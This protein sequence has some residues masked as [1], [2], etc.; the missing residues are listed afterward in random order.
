MQQVEMT[1]EQQRSEEEMIES[2]RGL[3]YHHG[4]LL[5]RN[6][7]VEMEDAISE[8]FL[9]LVRAAKSFDPARDVKFSSYATVR[10]RGAIIDYIRRESPVTRG[11][12]QRL[13]SYEDARTRL[14]TELGR[15]P[16]E[17]DIAGR[18]QLS[19]DQVKSVRQAQGLR[20]M[21]LNAERGDDLSIGETLQS[22]DD[23]EDEVVTKL[24]AREIRI[25][26]DKL[27]PRDRDVISRR[28]LRSESQKSIALSLGISESRV[29]QIERRAIS[30]L[31]AIAEHQELLE[32]A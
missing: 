29:C 27:E 18:L 8:G 9:G 4:H 12:F 19:D 20:V 15:D 16:S 31:R 3:V 26:V 28:F 2:C 14:V 13:R 1:V 17:Q 25:A 7:M 10:I 24:Q 6:G 30:R 21:S 22:D 23:I 5:A 32:A 11:Q